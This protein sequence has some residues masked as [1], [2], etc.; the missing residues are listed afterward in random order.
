MIIWVI[1]GNLCQWLY[2][3]TYTYRHTHTHTCHLGQG[4]H[5]S[6]TVRVFAPGANIHTYIHMCI[7]THMY[8][9]M[10]VCMYVCMYVYMY[11]CMCVC[12]CVWECMCVCVY[13]HLCTI[14]GA[15][16]EQVLCEWS[17]KFFVN[18]HS[19]S[20]W[21]ILQVRCVMYCTLHHLGFRMMM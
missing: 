17:F 18:H 4:K 5:T 20:L 2:T 19:S 3:D 15:G 8:V 13:F 1:K 16:A 21:M 7:A 11:V 14:W 9:C 10:H 12:V 6:N